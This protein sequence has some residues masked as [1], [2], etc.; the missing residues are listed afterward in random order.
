MSLYVLTAIWR[1]PPCKGGDLL[2]LLAIADNADE[3]G[4]AWPSIATIAKKAAMGER[5]ARKCIQKLIATGLISVQPGGGRN[6]TN[7]YQIT[8]NGIGHDAQHKKPEQNTGNRSSGFPQLNPEQDDT[9]PEPQFHKP[10][11][12]VQVNSQEPPNESS[13]K[14]TR[15]KTPDPV[16][17]ILRGVPGVTSD[18]ARSFMAYRR[19]H[20]SKA[21]TQTAARR[22]SFG[23]M[24]IHSRGGDPSDALGLAEER[25]W[26]TVKPDW[27]ENSKPQFKSIEG[28]RHDQPND[29]SDGLRRIVTAGAIGT[30]EK[31]WG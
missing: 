19:S 17:A 20:K 3:N 29:K 25:G 8:T 11:T 26:S 28:D 15:E 6:K 21:L 7:S 9:Y 14:R 1:A 5:G 24:E 18:A 4:F 13:K 2:C 23:L 30:S 27:Y 10:G 31:D 16:S 22:L 12:G